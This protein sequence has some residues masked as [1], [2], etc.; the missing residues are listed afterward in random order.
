MS[1]QYWYNPRYDAAWLWD[2]MTVHSELTTHLFTKVFQ[3]YDMFDPAIPLSIPVWVGMGKY[4]Y[5]IPYT[6]WEP[7]YEHLNN[8]TL[9]LFEKSGHTPQLEEAN[10]FDA[11]LLT[12]VDLQL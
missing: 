4:D 8:F 10:A 9:T 7:Q 3:A 5:V 2:D 6:L 11:A 1:P 12:W